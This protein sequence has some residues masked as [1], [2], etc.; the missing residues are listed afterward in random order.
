MAVT[1]YQ[2][3]LPADSVAITATGLASLAT[4][5]TRLVG[6]ALGSV[7]NRTN[8]DI[9]H[10]IS[11]ALTVG[12]TPTINTFIDVWLIPARSY[13]SGTPA[14]PS[15][16]DGSAGAETLPSAGVLQGLGIPLKTFW[17]DSTTSDRVY[18]AT[19]LDV[20]AFCGGTMPFDYQLFIAHNTGVNF[21]STGSNFTVTY[22]R[23]RFTGTS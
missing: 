19:A 3:N 7:S 5:S 14:W 9:T 16:F 12:T 22:T 10:L 17:V 13:T 8:L 6:Y 20:A 23:K 21:N 11:I 18:E 1:T 2:E 4:S 15:V